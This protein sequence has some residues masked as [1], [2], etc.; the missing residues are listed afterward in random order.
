MSAFEQLR[1][2]MASALNV[3]ASAIHPKTAHGSLAAWDSTGHIH[4]MVALEDAFGIHMEVED[5]SRLTSVSAILDY[6][7]GQGIE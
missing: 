1:D 7:K 3:D 5:F 6:L 2:A 4:V